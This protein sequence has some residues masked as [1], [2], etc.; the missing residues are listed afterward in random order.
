MPAPTRRHPHARLC[1]YF[2]KKTKNKNQS[3]HG[4][5]LLCIFCFCY[6]LW[7]GNELFRLLVADSL[8]KLQEEPQQ[9][10]GWCYFVLC[11]TTALSLWF[12]SLP[13]IPCTKRPWIIHVLS[14]VWWKFSHLLNC[15]V[16][17]SNTNRIQ[18]RLGKYC[19]ICSSMI[20]PFAFLYHVLKVPRASAYCIFTWGL[21]TSQ[22]SLH[23][24]LKG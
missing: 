3:Q 16:P 23:R 24:A 1:P 5:D 8:H 11:H 7:H 14:E 17:K 19:A 15:Q 2:K 9:G 6:N 18:T 12:Y 10:D 13:A 21:Q 22:M 4:T 20:V